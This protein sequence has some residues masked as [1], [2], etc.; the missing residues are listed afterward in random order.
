MP[1]SGRG[2]RVQS[3][4]PSP[5]VFVVVQTVMASSSG[6]TSQE[7]KDGPFRSVTCPSTSDFNL[8]TT[9]VPS[10][11]PARTS[12]SAIANRKTST[13]AVVGTAS[14]GSTRGVS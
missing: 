3:P 11:S 9:T 13:G 4:V 1:D 12:L 14:F 10:L 7:I 5:V 2:R 6:S 8:H